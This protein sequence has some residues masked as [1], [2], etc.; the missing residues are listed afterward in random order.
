MHGLT[1]KIGRFG[2][3]YIVSVRVNSTGLP[4]SRYPSVSLTPTRYCVH[5][6]EA[7]RKEKGRNI[8]ETRRHHTR[9]ENRVLDDN[10]D[11]VSDITLGNLAFSKDL[12]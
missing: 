9:V 8:G 6:G 11:M 2:P 7:E 5:W 10:N 12:G 3:L 1:R 4:M